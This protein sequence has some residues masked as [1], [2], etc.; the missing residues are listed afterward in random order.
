MTA[1]A[2]R[3]ATPLRIME[4]LWASWRTQALVAGIELGVF[5]H[6]AEGSRTPK[7]IA[8]AAQASE[9]G[10]ERLLNALVGIGY[11]TK[12]S[13]R[14]ELEPIAREFLVRGKDAYRGDA[15]QTVRLLWDSWARLTDVVRS[16]RPMETVD[17]EHRGREFFPKLVGAL[18]PG[19]FA[20]ARAA[21]GA[22]PARVRRR[23]K[24]ILDVAAGS[25]AWSI[26]FAQAIPGVRVT[27]LDFPEVTAIT[28][29]FTQRFAVADRYAYLEGNLREVDFGSEC[30][31]LVILGH[32]IH[33][34]GAEWGQKLVKKSHRALK[35]GGLLLIAEIIPNDTRTGPTLPLLFGLNM[36]LRTEHGDVFTMREYRT[37][38]KDTGFTKVASVQ[39]PA[40]SPLILATK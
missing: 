30:Y 21:A 37:W 26:P 29:Q 40:P 1:E 7:A 17:V 16:G 23:I 25:G 9:R 14:Y 10:I 8:R 33:S 18:F 20:A 12:K 39:V 31:D 11:L 4:D 22:L 38:L 13:D 32:I 3:N 15:A 27:A 36:L 19:S 2:Q 6:I 35:D 5:T 28:R 24:T 34:E